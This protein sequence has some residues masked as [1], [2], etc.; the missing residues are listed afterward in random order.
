MSF[1]YI[2]NGA[3]ATEMFS[4]FFEK[5]VPA[6]STLE[7]KHKLAVF[8]LI[9]GASKHVSAPLAK[10]YFPV[11]ASLIL[12]NVPEGSSP[13]TSKST[14]SSGE[15]ESES[16][17]EEPAKL[18]WS[19][20]ECLFYVVHNFARV[21]HNGLKDHFGI[22]VATGQPSD[23]SS[24]IQEA[25]ALF[26]GRFKRILD[27]IK[28]YRAQV[29]AVQK[30]ISQKVRETKDADEKKDLLGKKA[31]VRSAINTVENIHNT[32]APLLSRNGPR[33]LDANEI[34]LSWLGNGVVK[35]PEKKRP[36]EKKASGSGKGTKK[37]KQENGKGGKGGKGGKKKSD[38]ESGNHK[39]QKQNNGGAQK[40]KGGNVEKED[41]QSGGRKRKRRNNKN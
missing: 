3:D 2:A 1:K 38:N 24:R 18:N 19:V 34:A 39:K 37:V 31:S 41:S 36:A 14:S 28:P 23:F 40:K 10:K 26:T 20:I 27:S 17:E 16:K 30:K 21:H 13:T 22:F 35:R 8:K 5:A 4:F 12:E 32:V 11:V 9:A 33:I 15:G 29:E 25:K 7:D 6:L